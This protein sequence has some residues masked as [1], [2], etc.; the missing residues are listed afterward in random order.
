MTARRIATVCL[1]KALLELASDCRGAGAPT[2]SLAET[3][4]P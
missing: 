3:Y 2:E 4:Q 1:L